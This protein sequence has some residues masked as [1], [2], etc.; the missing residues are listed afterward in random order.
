MDLVQTRTLAGFQCDTAPRVL[1]EA[2]DTIASGDLD[3]DDRASLATSP[4][5]GQGRG[6]RGLMVRTTGHMRPLRDARGK[7]SFRKISSQ[8]LVI[9][10]PSCDLAMLRV[11][12]CVCVLY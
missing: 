6:L 2:L 12:V 3:E 5:A 9:Y 10:R 1:Q 11:C 8:P 7:R 4:D